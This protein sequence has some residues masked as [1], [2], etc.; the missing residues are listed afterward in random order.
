MSDSD[1]CPLADL[2]P[3]GDLHNQIR[4]CPFCGGRAEGNIDTGH[5]FAMCVR[6]GD[7]FWVEL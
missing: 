5:G 2:R 7:G 3:Y 1:E 6:C 4:Y